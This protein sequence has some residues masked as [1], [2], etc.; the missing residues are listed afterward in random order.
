M[1]GQFI[2]IVRLHDS[3]Y[4]S[5]SVDDFKS[6]KLPALCSYKRL[7][8]YTTELTEY[9]DI[10]VPLYSNDARIEYEQ[11]YKSLIKEAMGL[12][13][14]LEE[15]KSDNEMEKLIIYE[16]SVGIM[17]LSACLIEMTEQFKVHLFIF[18]FSILNSYF[19]LSF[20]SL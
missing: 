9:A 17:I 14:A 20:V 19:L 4:N 15:C 18:T 12:V 2:A 8:N 10:M 3:F 5:K 1:H 13:K 6:V 11:S 7:R 16:K